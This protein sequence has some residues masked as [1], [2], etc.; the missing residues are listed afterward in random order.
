MRIFKHFVPAFL[1]FLTACQDNI[2]SGTKPDVSQAASPQGV[3]ILKTDD[4]FSDTVKK[5]IRAYIQEK[6]GKATMTITYHSPAVRGR[7]IW[8]G[9]VPY[10]Q[11]WVTG[12]H[13]A[14]ALECDRDFRIGDQRVKAGKYA[15]F[16]IP[17]V[18]EW[19]FILNKNWNQ[20]LA[21]EYDEKENI[22]R[23]TVKP[24]SNSYSQERLMYEISP[25][26]DTEGIISITWEKTVLRVPVRIIN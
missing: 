14:T 18:D 4:G 13:S 1:F 15:V 8:G 12:A 2:P 26:T 16:T 22:L 3:I 6:I 23:Y 9:L 17:G 24:E 11:V 25:Q 5:S 10:G 19:I 21:D 7:I 20:H